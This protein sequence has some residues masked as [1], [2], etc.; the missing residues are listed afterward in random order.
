MQPSPRTD[1]TAVLRRALGE[2]SN[3]RARYHLRQALQYTVAAD[4]ECDDPVN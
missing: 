2:V 4:A 1:E 3:A